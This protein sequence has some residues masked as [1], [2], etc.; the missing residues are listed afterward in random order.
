MDKLPSLE[1]WFEVRAHVSDQH[2]YTRYDLCIRQDL[3]DTELNELWDEIVL[4]I[5]R[6]R[7]TPR[8]YTEWLKYWGNST[9]IPPEW[10]RRFR[11]RFYRGFVSDMAT[12][13]AGGEIQF[14]DTALQGYIGELMLYVVQFQCHEDRI[15]SVPKKPKQYPK[16]SGIDCLELCGSME[17]GDS[18]HYIAWECKGSVSDTI[19]TYPGK[20]Y[21]QHLHETPKTFAEMVDLLADIYENHGEN[22]DS[23]DE[24]IRI[25]IG[26]MIDDFYMPTPS[27]R[28]CF[29]ACVSYSGKRFARSDAFSTFQFRFKGNLSEDPRCRQVSLCAVG[30]FSSIVSQVRKKIWNKLLR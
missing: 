4:L 26:E 21:N 5:A 23:G 16:D 1:R 11:D 10:K 19:G 14:D 13:E 6:L 8:E 28:K 25:F 18:L 3:P 20:I 7:L 22:E 24:P 29:G 27:Q 9:P 30:D 12:K 2:K 17:D 15:R